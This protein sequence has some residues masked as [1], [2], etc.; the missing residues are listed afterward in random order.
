M[1]QL[2]E[3]Q[4]LG[5]KFITN[6]RQPASQDPLEDFTENFPNVVDVLMTQ[7]QPEKASTHKSA[8][9]HAGTVFCTSWP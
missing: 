4:F 8:K 6:V 3:W 1:R 2:Q 7:S 9:T 5:L